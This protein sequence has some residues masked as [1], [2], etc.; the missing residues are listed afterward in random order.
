MNIR[1]AMPEESETIT[2]LALRSK[3]HWGY[4]ETFIVQ[5]KHAL[6]VTPRDLE[7]KSM[8]FEVCELNGVV[9]GFYGLEFINAV[10][11][12]L[13]YL[14]VEPTN[15]GLGIGGKLFDAAIKN[16]KKRGVA[17]LDILSDP[18]AKGFYLAKGA[19]FVEYRQ[20]DAIENRQIPFLTY[21]INTTTLA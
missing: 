9:A 15:I 5:C 4:D 13:T 3:A 21:S 10:T 16:V 18:E 1:K 11:A 12:E 6:T 7:N 17:S 2:Q 14:F 8:Y 19:R 20:S